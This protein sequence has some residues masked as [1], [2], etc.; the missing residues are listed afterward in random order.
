MILIT[1]IGIDEYR[2]ARVEIIGI[3]NGITVNIPFKYNSD[4]SNCINPS[5][6]QNNTR[7]QKGQR[8]HTNIKMNRNILIQVDFKRIL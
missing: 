6:I 5:H 8:K 2:A 7:K 1:Y 3:E 4:F